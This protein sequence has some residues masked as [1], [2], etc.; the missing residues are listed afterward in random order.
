M[1][2]TNAEPRYRLFC[3]GFNRSCTELCSTPFALT[4]HKKEAKS[5]IL[6]FLLSFSFSS[7]S[8][9]SSSSHFQNKII[10]PRRRVVFFFWPSHDRNDDCSPRQMCLKYSSIRFFLFLSSFSRSSSFLLLHRE[11][12]AQHMGPTASS[13][14]VL[15]RGFQCFSRGTFDI[16]RRM[17]TISL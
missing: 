12:H 16:S 14:R 7:S 3:R 2:E 17:S 11:S 10:Y 8:S 4:L 1:A 15:S 5:S 13:A 9:S 6:L